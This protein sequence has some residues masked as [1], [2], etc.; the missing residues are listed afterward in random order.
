[1]ADGASRDGSPSPATPE[2]ARWRIPSLQ[3][4]CLFVIAE[5]ADRLVSVERLPEPVVLALLTLIM[6]QLRLTPRLVR[7]FEATGFPSVL[8]CVRSRASCRWG[9]TA[10]VCVGGG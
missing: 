9:R 6:H 1:M 4:R 3:V 7:V 5:N 8:R 10:C 2:A